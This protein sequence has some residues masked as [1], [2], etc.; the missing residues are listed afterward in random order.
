MLQGFN[1]FSLRWGALTIIGALLIDIEFLV[2][3][4]SF[5]L[6]HINLGLKTIAKDYIHTEKIYIMFSSAIKICYIELIRCAI[7]L[8]V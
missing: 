3:N 7:E 4:V 5:C 2:L 1:W 8:F 6:L